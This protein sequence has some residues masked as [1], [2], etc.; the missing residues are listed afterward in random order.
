MLLAEPRAG[1]PA[2]C[3]RSPPRR[4]RL[5]RPVNHGHAHCHGPRGVAAAVRAALSFPLSAF[6]LCFR[7][8]GAVT[9]AETAFPVIHH[10]NGSSG[11][12][13]SRCAL[14]L[15]DTTPAA[16]RSRLV[17]IVSNA[18][19]RRQVIQ[20]PSAHS[21]LQLSGRSPHKAAARR[22]PP[23]PPQTPYLRSRKLDCLITRCRGCTVLMSRSP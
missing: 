8:R 11:T 18:V 13:I 4:P 23:F 3:H 22:P 9:W 6:R 16:C 14:Q 5:T 20:V 7:G 15:A 10:T 1:I 21:S 2:Q 12:E 19:L 17:V